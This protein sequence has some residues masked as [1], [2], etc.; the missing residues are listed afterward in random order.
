[1]KQRVKH[2]TRIAF[3]VATGS[4]LLLAAAA[5][6]TTAEKQAAKDAAKD[7]QRRLKLESAPPPGWPEMAHCLHNA[8]TS[9]PGDEDIDNSGRIHT[10]HAARTLCALELAA[11]RPPHLPD[12]NCYAD[13][14]NAYEAKYNI[15]GD[16]TWGRSRA[17]AALACTPVQTSEPA[18]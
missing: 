12:A 2:F 11:E 9:V 5:C 10:T 8:G 16:G 13:E 17:Y 14:L 3:A 6:D 4:V 7:A 15:N 1:M 18:P